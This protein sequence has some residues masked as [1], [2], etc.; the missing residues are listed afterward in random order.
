MVLPRGARRVCA[1]QRPQEV[2]GHCSRLRR[3]RSGVGTRGWAK[4]LNVARNRRR[5]D[6]PC[7]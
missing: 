3:P 6:V 1:V 2:K 4:D 5:L 7:K